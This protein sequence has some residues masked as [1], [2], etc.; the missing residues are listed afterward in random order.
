MSIPEKMAASGKADKE[1]AE[2]LGLPTPTVW[3][4]RKGLTRPNVV[5]I[6]SLARVI[7]CKPLELIPEEGG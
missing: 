2:E 3:R 1:I 6:R 5:N 7:G 4:W